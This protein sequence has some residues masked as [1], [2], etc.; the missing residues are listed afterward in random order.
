MAKKRGPKRTDRREHAPIGHA[1]RFLYDAAQ[2]AAERDVAKVLAKY[3]D[4]AMVLSTY[5]QA[6]RGG[7]IVAELE[8]LLNLD[9]VLD[10]PSRD[11]VTPYFNWLKEK[12]HLPTWHNFY[13]GE[14][15]PAGGAPYD[16]EFVRAENFGQVTTG[17]GVA[18]LASGFATFNPG[19]GVFSTVGYGMGSAADVRAGPIVTME[20]H[21]RPADIVL[22]SNVLLD[23]QYQLSANLNPAFQLALSAT[24][25]ISVKIDL[26][27]D[28]DVR[29]LSG[30]P[31]ARASALKPVKYAEL[32]PNSTLPP[33][34]SGYQEIVP[35]NNLQGS[36]L[37]VPVTW[38]HTFS[39]PANCRV[40]VG[41][42][43][44]PFVTATGYRGSKFHR[45]LGIADGRA[46]GEVTSV[47]AMLFT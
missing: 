16:E 12:F 11:R 46:S 34:V 13:P 30:V 39:A 28:I 18:T 1:Q 35:G 19:S 3:L 6:P 8:D 37:G 25:A 36:A 29:T 14:H 27:L 32:Q 5:H 42:I 10:L 17:S 47:Q 4:P 21:Q 33:F 2:I 9:G 7:R 24:E 45:H 31:L 44:A 23:Y 41:V 38:E 43:V 15:V 22:T 40:R 20:T 26:L